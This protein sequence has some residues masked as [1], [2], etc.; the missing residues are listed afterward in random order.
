MLPA[1]KNNAAAGYQGPVKR[2]LLKAAGLLVQ[3][4]PLPRVQR[5][6]GKEIR[7]GMIR[8]TCCRKWFHT[9]K[10]KIHT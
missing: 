8:N 9:T 4:R 3:H 7:A 5:K 2:E 1:L 6:S 10:T